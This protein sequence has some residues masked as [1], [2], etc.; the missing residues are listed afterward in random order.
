MSFGHLAR[1][2]AAETSA[3]SPLLLDSSPLRPNHTRVDYCGFTH[4]QALT[5]KRSTDPLKLHGSSRAKAHVEKPTARCGRAKSF[6]YEMHIQFSWG[7]I[8]LNYACRLLVFLLSLEHIYYACVPASLARSGPPPSALRTAA[9]LPSSGVCVRSHRR[10]FW[11]FGRDEKT[12]YE[13]DI[14]PTV[15]GELKYTKA[16]VACASAAASKDPRAHGRRSSV[17]SAN[18][19]LAALTYSSSRWIDHLRFAPRPPLS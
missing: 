7:H 19:G 2:A 17:P 4:P 16:G 13:F 1:L 14:T 15:M 8:Y 10:V 11:Y 12:P 3:A 9:S 6:A 5:Q 18:I